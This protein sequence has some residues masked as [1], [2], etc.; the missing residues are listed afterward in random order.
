VDDEFVIM[1]TG[2]ELSL[3][4][5]YTAPLSGF[6]RDF[7]FREYGY[8]KAP[9]LATGDS[10]EPMPFKNMTMYPYDGNNEN[11][12]YDNHTDYLTTYQTRFREGHHTAYGIHMANSSYFTI[13]NARGVPE[14]EF[15]CE[16][17]ILVDNCQEG[18]IRHCAFTDGWEY[19]FYFYYSSY[20][21]I[22]RN[23]ICN[24]KDGIYL[25][26]SSDNTITWNKIENNT[27]GFT[28]AHLDT[29]SN[30]NEIHKNCFIDNDPQA[31]DDGENKNNNWNGNYWSDFPV[32]G[33]KY[34][35]QGS[36]NSIDHNTNDQCPPRPPVQAPSLTPI[37]ILVLI[38]LLSL[39]AIVCLRKK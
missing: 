7:V 23:E 18:T 38:G 27:D 17:G 28:G 34:N 10:I 22:S 35:I 39:L 15:D 8:K 3:Q 31:L 36:A 20:C 5:D 32:S 14:N 33:G 12:D 21:T 16:Y 26:C 19:G 29:D 30:G 6:E 9:V 4:F 1:G 13:N 2:D 24:N 11:Y 25:D 37:G